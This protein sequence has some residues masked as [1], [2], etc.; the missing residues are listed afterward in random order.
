[1]IVLQHVGIMWGN[2]NRENFSHVKLS[3][4]YIAHN[5][6]VYIYMYAIVCYG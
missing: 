4:G 3:E 2:Q 1:M 5:V 6:Y